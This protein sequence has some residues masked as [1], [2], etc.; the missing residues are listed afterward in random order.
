[1]Q[2]IEKFMMQKAIFLYWS[3]K[4]TQ[5]QLTALSASFHQTL[6]HKA[7]H[8]HLTE[9]HRKVWAWS[10]CGQDMTVRLCGEKNK[11]IKTLWAVSHFPVPWLAL[12]IS[13]K[14]SLMLCCDDATALSSYVSTDQ[15]FRYLLVNYLFL[16]HKGVLTQKSYFDYSK[17]FLH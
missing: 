4:S 16:P 3:L 6:W 8:L 9:L 17:R 12:S 5:L 13:S 11:T 15:G 14:G 10:G 1:M 2:A 7:I